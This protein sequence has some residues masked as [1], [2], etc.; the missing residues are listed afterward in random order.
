M[1]PIPMP[2]FFA[3][4]DF[5]QLSLNW[6]ERRF[7]IAQGPDAAP[8][9]VTVDEMITAIQTSLA[10]GRGWKIGVSPRYP[11]IANTIDQIIPHGCN[12]YLSFINNGRLHRSQTMVTYNCFFTP[13]QLETLREEKKI[14]DNLNKDTARVFPKPPHR[15]EHA[16]SPGTITS[17]TLANFTK[18]D[19]DQSILF[20]GLMAHARET[21]KKNLWKLRKESRPPKAT[22][23]VECYTMSETGSLTTTMGLN[24]KIS[25]WHLTSTKN[26]ETR[27]GDEDMETASNADSLVLTNEPE[28][29]P[30]EGPSTA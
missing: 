3:P 24:A 7:E 17:A 1:S 22:R 10:L 28:D 25:K 4:S 26:E 6:A 30:G 20:A 11:E 5:P 9:T 8:I 27:R 16:G 12:A 13:S 14:S 18:S 21:Q 19:M 2:A 23:G 15:V 29:G